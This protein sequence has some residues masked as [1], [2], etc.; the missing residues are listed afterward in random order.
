MDIQYV[1]ITPA[2]QSNCP[3]TDKLQTFVPKVLDITVALAAARA[4]FK[5]RLF[6]T[7]RCATA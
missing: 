2:G 3:T 6:A 7:S 5:L 1:T 4:R